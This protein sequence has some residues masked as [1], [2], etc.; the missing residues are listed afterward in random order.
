MQQYCSTLRFRCSKR[1]K[2]TNADLETLQCASARF[3][4][5][6]LANAM[7][8]MSAYVS[9]PQHTSA[10]ALA[11]AMLHTSAYVSMRQH[12]SARALAN[13]MLHT[14]AYVSMRQ[15]TSARALANAMVLLSVSICTFVEQV[16]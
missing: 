10:R 7:L 12:T 11:N 16:N 9:M 14:S 2:I 4:S 15:H 8:H 6:A 3:A 1:Y 13:A 5:R